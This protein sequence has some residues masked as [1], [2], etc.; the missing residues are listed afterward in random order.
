MKESSRITVGELNV[1]GAYWKGQENHIKK[2]IIDSFEILKKS[3]GKT[4]QNCQDTSESLDVI[5]LTE[6]CNAQCEII[7][8]SDELNAYEW[9]VSNN[10]NIPD[11]YCVVI[12]VKKSLL[13][14]ILEIT[15]DKSTDDIDLLRVRFKQKNDK[16]IIVIG[17][18]MTTGLPDK[19]KQYDS[20]REAFANQLLPFIRNSVDSD[21]CI[22]AGDFN[23]GRCLGNLNKQY[24][25]A[26]YYGKDHIKY[27]P[28][29]IKD[30]FKN[31]GFEML[32]IG[33]GWGIPT[34]GKTKEKYV[35]NDHIFVR[36]LSLR[37][38][39]CKP[40]STGELSD[41]AIIWAEFESD[42]NAE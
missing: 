42:V 33:D 5:V 34:W 31:M 10:A 12:G 38:K 18:R 26:N 32:D 1:Q 25:S 13:S 7:K 15:P 28:N 27:N 41:H 3:S 19:K 8:K 29:I 17:C 23:N 16:R 9:I 14:C 40:V 22:V 35:P 20:E 11:R 21:V 36:G 4:E 39:N 37:D 6:V 2:Q 24:S 30:R